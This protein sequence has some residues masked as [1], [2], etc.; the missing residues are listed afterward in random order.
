M[1]E[2]DTGELDLLAALE[3][4]QLKS[5]ATEAN[6]TGLRLRVAMALKDDRAKLQFVRRA[7][8][9]WRPTGASKSSG[10]IQWRSATISRGRLT[11]VKP[12]I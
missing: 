1:A 5:I 12:K 4:G 9:R 11:S 2:P 10:G 6:L 7:S 3:Q 8:S